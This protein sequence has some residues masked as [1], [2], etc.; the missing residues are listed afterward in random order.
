[1]GCDQSQKMDLAFNSNRKLESELE[2]IEKKQKELDAE[3]EK[4]LEATQND[5]DDVS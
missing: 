4:L 3:N 5:I 2:K 1:M